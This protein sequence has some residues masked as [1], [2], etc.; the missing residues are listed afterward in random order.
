MGMDFIDPL[1]ATATDNRF[2]LNMG[3]YISRFEVPFACKISNVEDVI[4]CLRLFFA[5]YRRSYVFYFDRGHHFDCDKLREFLR[6]EGIAVSYSPSTLYKSTGMIEVMNRIL[7]SVVR[8][9][10]KEW[11]VVLADT[12]N[13]VNSRVIN[14][15]GISSKSVVLDSLSKTAVITATLKTLS[16]RDIHI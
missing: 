3:Y 14:Y 16:K 8:K 12:A 6:H 13:A 15:L 1:S 2:I 10:D 4:Q 11:D 7:K 9:L 5:R